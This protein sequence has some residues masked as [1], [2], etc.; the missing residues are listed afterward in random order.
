MYEKCK[1]N[2][3]QLTEEEKLKYIGSD[4]PIY[5]SSW[6]ERVMYYF[7]HNKNVV[8]WSSE[9]VVIPYKNPLDGKVHRYYVDF[10][11]EMM[12]NSGNIGKYLVEVKPKKQCIPPIVPKNKTA[13]AKARYNKEAEVFIINQAKWK[14]ANA[15]SESKGWKFVILTEEDLF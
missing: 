15:F 7:T 11:C 1:K 4:L 8:R 14:A 12:S 2:V 9:K 5:R 13:K 6:E 3:Y 10:Y